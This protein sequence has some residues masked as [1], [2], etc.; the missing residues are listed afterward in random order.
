ML[1]MNYLSHNMS[2]QLEASIFASLII[3]IPKLSTPTHGYLAIDT[4]QIQQVIV[5]EECKC[6][7]E[8]VPFDVAQDAFPTKQEIAWSHTMVDTFTLL[9]STTSPDER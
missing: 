4:E 6:P 8:R 2:F 9:Y 3:R 1:S 7:P 5:I